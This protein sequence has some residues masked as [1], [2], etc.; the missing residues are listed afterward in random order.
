MRITKPI[1]IAEVKLRSPFGFQSKLSNLQL[2]DMAIEFG[3]IVSLHS[4]SDFGGGWL[5]LEEATELVHRAGKLVLAKGIHSAD[6]EVRL[7]RDCGADLVLVVGRL[8]APE[9]QPICLL[10]QIPTHDDQRVDRLVINQRDL[11]SGLR[12]YNLNDLERIRK[13]YP[14]RWL[15]QASFIQKPSDVLPDYDAFMV[16]EH[17]PEFCRALRKAGVR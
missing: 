2:L 14:H 1:F 17:L 8:P 11:R 16:G 3:D 5:W 12:R 10:E 9:L 15:C 4:S 13:Q 6:H 7:A